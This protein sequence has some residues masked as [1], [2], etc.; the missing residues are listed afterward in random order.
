MQINM[1]IVVLI[2]HVLG[3]YYLQ[4]NDMAEY[5]KYKI[6]GVIK[7]ALF[8]CIPFILIFVFTKKSMK[9]FLLFIL[10][11][12]CHYTIDLVKFCGYKMYL[13]YCNTEIKKKIIKKYIKPSLVYV[14]DQVI[15]IVS[16]CLLT[17][18]FNFKNVTT[19]N[20]VNYINKITNL[21]G[22]NVLK[23]ILLVLVIYKPANITFKMLFS[24]CKPGDNDS[25][26]KVIN[27][28]AIIGFLER[29][30]IAV[31]I[32]FKQ[33]SAIGFILT[34]KSV[35][36]YNAISEKPKFAEYYLIGTLFSTLFVIVFFNI[37]F[38]YK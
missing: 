21:S 24:S 31:F 32:Y 6:K 11:C 25:N 20:L 13:K 2:A 36:R 34:A 1:I 23:W 17:S 16:I 14:L 3:D 12:L 28:G 33:Y 15:H 10:M 30:I 8:Y 37:I 5:K 18:L 26:D 29:L 4:D 27:N 7:H 19:I 9:L 22:H 38:K 35:A